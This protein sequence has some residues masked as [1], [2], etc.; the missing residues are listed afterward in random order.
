MKN[1]K[2]KI[3]PLSFCVSMIFSAQLLAENTDTLLEEVTVKENIQNGSAEYGYLV[4]E[5]KQVGP[6]GTKSLQD[7]PYSMTVMPKELIEN[8]VAGDINQI[9]KINPLI[10]T[11]DSVSV[12]NT[13]WVTYRGFSNETAILDGMSMGGYLYNVSME[14]M[15]RI[16]TISGLTGFMYGVGNV[17]GTSNYVLKRPTST[18][19]TNVTIGN[20]GGGQYFGHI[21]V[22]GP[23]DEKGKFAY[24]LNA[25][26]TDGDTEIAGQSVEKELISGAIDWKVNDNLLLQVEAAH[27]H[28]RL[29]GIIP[30]TFFRNM[31]MPAAFDASKQYSPN[32]TYNETQS[33]RIGLNATWNINDIFT[34]RSAY[35]HKEDEIESIKTYYYMYGNGNF[36]WGVTKSAPQYQTADGIYSYLDASFDTKGIEHKVTM[37]I[38]ADKYKS[39]Q[40]VDS[41]INRRF[42]NSNMYDYI[43][44]SEPNIGTYGKGNKYKSS[45]S[46]N[47]NII[48]GDEIIFNNQWSILAG[49]N[50]SNIE[51]TSYSSTGNKT[52]E[53]DK[54]AITPTVS[55]IYKPIEN[56][57]TY[58]TYIESLEQGTIVG[59]TY[60][61]ANAILDPL[62]SKQYE[63][64][65][66]YAFTEKV[67]LSTALF[68]IEKS[69][70]YSDD[71]TE[72]GTYVQ[73]G[74]EVHE[75]IELTVTG[76]VTDR[77]TVMT[78]GTYMD[79]SIEDSNDAA[80]KGKEPTGVASKLAKIYAEYDLANIKGVT[81]TG[82]AY[83]TGE[84]NVD[85]AN[86]DKIPG[87]TLFDAGARYKTK[88]S[89]Y[90]TT[91][92]LNVANLTD[93]DYWA[94]TETLGTPRN[95]AFSM[96]VEF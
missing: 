37:G 26:Y 21:D 33:N 13:P 18:K 84:K 5:V 58:T 71:G 44:S 70:Q 92:R 43:N 36:D 41:F 78:G 59:D 51:T 32:W 50:R 3:I 83:Y 45:D 6:W 63:V 86:T 65:A 34:L 95:I 10:G 47:T 67:L 52:A 72:F 35:L 24:R 29:D 1:I 89:N 28:Y 54:T 19:I 22:G 40:Y 68:R 8:T 79:L 53:Y 14:E 20:Y 25:A 66:K 90:P 46:A 7:T 82:G 30:R 81:L 55:L 16:E 91:F 12:W 39:E 57:T 64:G 56:L 96:K 62:V 4:E 75:G 31:D 94:S 17:G 38:S 93:K 61:N 42:T 60:K 9:Y 23:I 27:Q 49:F 85:S 74:L 87:V 48:L 2:R 88:V 15:E 73:D 76:K 77:L 80:L 69:N 11:Q